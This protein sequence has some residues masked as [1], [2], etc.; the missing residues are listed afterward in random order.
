MEHDHLHP[1]MCLS[2]GRRGVVNGPTYKGL[3]EQERVQQA[4][5][6][7]AVKVVC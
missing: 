2:R 1:L 3:F 6:A 4:V 5:E 7:A